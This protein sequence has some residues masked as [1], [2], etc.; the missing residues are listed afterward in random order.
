VGAFFVFEIKGHVERKLLFATVLLLLP[1]SRLLWT[2][3]TKGPS[4]INNIARFDFIDSKSFLG[5]EGR[6]NSY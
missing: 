3:N 4:L 5:C 1:F 2:H 6:I